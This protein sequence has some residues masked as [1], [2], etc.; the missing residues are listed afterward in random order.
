M[1]PRTRGVDTGE[2]TIRKVSEC[3]ALDSAACSFGV[4][5]WKTATHL[6]DALPCVFAKAESI[7]N[8][9]DMAH[10]SYAVLMHYEVAEAKSGMHDGGTCAEH[11]MRT[12]S[13]AA[14]L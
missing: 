9:E 8:P 3:G 2:R 4:L 5:T 13:R 12:A 10:P 6:R 11:R 14:P 7:N 1:Q